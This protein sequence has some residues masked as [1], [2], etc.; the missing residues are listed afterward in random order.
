M[1]SGKHFV[2][3]FNIGLVFLLS[4]LLLIAA[5]SAQLLMVVLPRVVRAHRFGFGGESLLDNW[6]ANIEIWR[7]PARP[8]AADQANCTLVLLKPRQ[9]GG[10][11]RRKLSH[12]ELCESPVVADIIGR[13]LAGDHIVDSAPPIRS[14]WPSRLRGAVGRLLPDGGTMPLA[15]NAIKNLLIV[16]VALFLVVRP[17][18][19]AASP[20]ADLRWLFGL[21]PDD[22]VWGYYLTEMWSLSPWRMVNGPELRLGPLTYMWSHDD[23][24]RFSLS[25]QIFNL[26]ER[27]GQE[28][29]YVAGAQPLVAQR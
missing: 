15:S 8:F 22:T 18:F 3:S 12:S 16:N 19:Q 6:L 17:L 5:A 27:F 9:L 23:G 2:L 1:E 11:R 20:G 13:W 10:V 26:V 7:E 28:S 25:G 4:P 14:H 24:S 29:S 21:N